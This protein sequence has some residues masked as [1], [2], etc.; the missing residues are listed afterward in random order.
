MALDFPQTT[1]P[2]DPPDPPDPS[3]AIHLTSS[4]RPSRHAWVGV[5][6]VL[7]GLL[8]NTWAIE[9]LFVIDED[10]TSRLVNTGIV[11]F[12]L[13][14]IGVGLWLGLSRSALSVLVWLN[15]L[16]P[17]AL[18][19]SLYWLV[20][21]SLSVG[22]L[23]GGYGS[24]RE[25]H[26]IDPQREMRTVFRGIQTSEELILALTLQL[27]A[28]S[29]SVMNLSFPDERSAALFDDQVRVIG[30]ASSAQP[31]LGIQD[32]A[33]ISAHPDRTLP[34]TSLAS[35]SNSPAPSAPPQSLPTVAATTRTWPIADAVETQDR[36]ALRLWQPLLEQV[37]YFERAEFKIKTGRFLDETENTYETV[38]LFDGVARLQSGHWA[39]LNSVQTLHWKQAAQP[40]GTA[41]EAQWKIFDWRT[42]SLQ[43]IETEQPLFVEVLDRALIDPHDVAK[44][45][46]S[47]YEQLMVQYIHDHA[48]V[49]KTHKKFVALAALHH[50]GLSVVDLDRDGFDDLYVMPRWGENMFFRNRGDGTFEEIAAELGL[51]ITDMTS[52]AIF[53]D[54]D[55]DGDADA[56]LSRTFAP[57]MYLVNEN[58]RFTDHTEAF[59]DAPPLPLVA[60]L[61]AV[62]YNQDGLL[63]LYLSTY[64][65]Y[66]DY[67][68]EA[69]ARQINQLKQ[70]AD[71][72]DILNFPGPSNV[73][74][75]NVGGGRFAVATAVS[76]LQVFKNTFQ[77][78]WSDF[79]KDGD[80]DVYLASD[81]A[82]NNMFRNDG[83][84]RFTDITAQ[85][86]TADIGFGMGASW[87]DY[88]NDGWQDLYVTNMYS[89][90][91]G[92]ITAQI[93]GLDPRLVKFARGNS[94]FRN[95]G[96][97]SLPFHKVSGLT[98]PHL[99]VE[100]AGWGWGSQFIDV[101]NDGYLDIYAPNGYFTAPQEVTRPVDT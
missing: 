60:S 94:L 38:L 10:I 53:A 27:Q 82:P 32:V 44:A 37:A 66:T 16:L 75:R 41:L 73:L 88:D 98:P 45:R 28:L 62:D 57:S 72:H 18:S 40:N 36:D 39:A 81:L 15:R 65:P 77:A 70:S 11:A 4:A 97:P 78:S 93:P 76:E 20:V 54:F 8:F 23:L 95:A 25:L 49:K 35:A 50:P 14:C 59:I 22:V 71:A 92:R 43:M 80:P 19:V 68:S 30:L 83:K 7:V 9:R 51:N 69:D 13:S 89:D 79:D 55:N 85:T 64:G 47:L 63:D 87:G 48:Q 96:Q 3:D 101:D 17:R 90:V 29:K 5:L 100:K 2:P 33:S 12:Q 84:G 42:N 6:L 61:S 24:L 67:L 74:L 99:L 26:I 91:G 86:E 21:C 34:N 52:S 56:F 31:P 58:G 46:A 1:S